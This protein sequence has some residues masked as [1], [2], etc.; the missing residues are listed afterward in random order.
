V[1]KN[2]TRRTTKQSAKV[3]TAVAAIV[4]AAVCTAPSA[5]AADPTTKFRL[6]YGASYA[7]GTLRW[8]QRSVDVDYSIKASYCRQLQAFGF[9]QSGNKR[10]YRESLV[11][12]N[13]TDSDTRNVPVDVPGGAKIIRLDLVDEKGKLLDSVKCVPG[14]DCLT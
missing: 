14:A 7:V 12:C 8:H 13:S 6:E 9:D 3:A 2:L 10:G 5:N 11:V 1:L 4:A